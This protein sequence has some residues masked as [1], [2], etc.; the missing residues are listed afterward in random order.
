MNRSRLWTALLVAVVVALAAGTV[1]AHAVCFDDPSSAYTFIDGSA[2]CAYSGGGCSYCITAGTRSPDSWDLCYYD[3][4]T[5]DMTCS[6]R[7]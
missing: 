3:W 1:P 6:T 2:V 5:G 4:A 7:Y